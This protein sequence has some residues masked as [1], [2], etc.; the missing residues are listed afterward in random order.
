M[1][2]SSS[3]SLIQ[4]MVKHLLSSKED[5]HSLLFS[6][7]INPSILEDSNARIPA[8][9]VYELWKQAEAQTKDSHFG[10]RMGES[11]QNNPGGNL[12]FSLMINSPTVYY[13][14][15]KFCRYHGIMNDA[16]QPVL[17]IQ[18]DMASLSWKMN[19]SWPN[20]S[21]HISELMICIFQSILNHLTDN[22]FEP[23]EVRFRHA[24]P[25]DIS[26]HQN[27]FPSTILFEQKK[28]ELVL[29][30][31]ILDR[32]IFL[33]DQQLLETVEHHATNL[34]TRLR[35]QD[36]WKDRVLLSINKNMQGN[37]PVISLI[38]KDLAVSTRYL[39]NKLCEENTSFQKLLDKARKEKALHY[40]KNQ[41][42]PLVDIAFLLGFSEQSTFNHTFKR[43]TGKTPTQYRQAK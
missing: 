10:L 15:D 29:E 18:K 28:D 12:L 22:R 30:K 31:S 7:G 17:E 4:M 43:L 23:T 3:S 16:I 2:L 25:K 21:R 35:S 1:K 34:T 11:M 5:P 26:V 39:Q 13:A 14:L 20:P 27:I 40:L 8:H 6:A 9:Q 38:A 24:K 36:S 42:M 33:S 19:T 32:K 37:K 41:D